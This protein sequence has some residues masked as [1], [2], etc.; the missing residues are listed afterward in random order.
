QA[1]AETEPEKLRKRCTP[2]VGKHNIFGVGEAN[3]EAV[4]DIFDDRDFYVQLLKEVLSGTGISQKDEEKQLL[5]EIAG[6]RSQK[7]KAQKEVERRAS[8]GRKIRYRPIEKLQNFMSGRPRGSLS[9]DMD[10]SEPLSE[11]ACQALLSS[12]FAPPRA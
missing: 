3:E 9:T 7:R 5:A 6:R 12:L 1:V 4:Q 10:E 8:K 11:S 2:P